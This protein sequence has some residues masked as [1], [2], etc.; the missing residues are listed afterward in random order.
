MSVGTATKAAAGGLK[1]LK[2]GAGRARE[3]AMFFTQALG[4]FGPQGRTAQIAISGLA[5]AFMGGGGLVLALG[6][7]QALSRIFA[8]RLEEQRKAA[9]EARKAMVALADQAGQI[10]TS[11]DRGAVAGAQLVELKKQRRKI[12]EEL[13]AAQEADDEDR[14]KAAQDA[15]TK[16]TNDEIQIRFRVKGLLAVEEEKTRGE[17]VAKE[18]EANEK[19]TKERLDLSARR[20]DLEIE[21]AN[22]VFAR[23]YEAWQKLQASVLA[24]I[25]EDERRAEAIL[26]EI[27][28]PDEKALNDALNGDDP[29]TAQDKTNKKVQE[30][31]DLQR[32][33]ADVTADATAQFLTGQMT[34][35]QAIRSIAQTVI[36]SAIKSIMAKALEAG[37]G[38][39]ASQASTPVVGPILAVAA[40]GAVMSQVSG[41]L[42]QMPS[43]RG[44]WWDTGNYEGLAVIHQKEMVLP[45][46]EAEMVRRGAGGVTINVAAYDGRG[47]DRV[48]SNNGSALSRTL[49]RMDRKGTI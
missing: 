1:E 11:T 12:E 48:L 34:A 25:D 8:A 9:E 46:R 2:E 4:E 45:A 5:G 29:A 23:E 14:I 28:A 19:I 10:G 17:K 24:D 49:R 42:G 6:A 39:A 36:Q 30:G 37:A 16:I 15:L 21:M 32:Q 26:S 7:A 43:A 3:T 41:L 47:F 40:M 35:Q 22:A 33:M 38:A 44:G 27:G 18:R 13:K 31:I 20:R